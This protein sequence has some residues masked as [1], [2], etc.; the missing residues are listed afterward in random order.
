MT[1]HHIFSFSCQ[2]LHFHLDFHEHTYPTFAYDR[3]L[4]YRSLSKTFVLLEKGPPIRIVTDLRTCW[5]A[6]IEGCNW[7]T[8]EVPVKHCAVLDT[9]SYVF[10]AKE[11][12]PER[13]DEVATIDALPF[14]GTLDFYDLPKDTANIWNVAPRL[15]IQ[16]DV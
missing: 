9:P 4:C 14:R 13:F 12:G 11:E 3:Q 5:D 1:S 6:Y 7:F 15:R 10:E 8:D 16:R 2:F